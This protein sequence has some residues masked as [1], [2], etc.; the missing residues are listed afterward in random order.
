L[1]QRL[2]SFITSNQELSQLSGK[3]RQLRALQLLYEK[4]TPPSL[5]RASHVIQIEQ[6]VL[7]LG[8]NNSAIAAKLRQMTPELMQLLKLHS[9]EVT[10]IQVRVQVTMPPA[11]PVRHT[12]LV[13][14]H[15][16]KEL[17]EL[18]ESLPDSPLKS[19]LQRLVNNKKA[20]Q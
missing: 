2:N 18:A 9:C 5:L 1:P 8:A 7:T 12:A 14:A 15:G 10:G 11:I 16:K 19:A 4:I 13:S 3:V 17:C 6:N 20:N